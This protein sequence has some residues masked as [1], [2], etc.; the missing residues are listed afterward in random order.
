MNG[1]SRFS[2]GRNA[3][4]ARHDLVASSF[5]LKCE[6]WAAWLWDGGK[7]IGKKKIIVLLYFVMLFIYSWNVCVYV[8]VLFTCI[9][10]C[11]CRYA[12]LCVPMWR[13]KV[14]LEYLSLL[15]LTFFFSFF[16]P[17][18]SLNKKFIILVRLLDSKP[19]GSAVSSPPPSSVGVIGVH[20][21]LLAFTWA[22]GFQFRSLCLCSKWLLHWAPSP[23]LTS[24]YFNF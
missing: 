20:K 17:G 2:Q 21:Q 19:L 7:I 12:C 15:L 23:V 24:F 14:I 18:L 16:W 3:V 13:T 11:V 9:H 4:A 22:P 8:H 5:T 1:Y 6:L 10:M